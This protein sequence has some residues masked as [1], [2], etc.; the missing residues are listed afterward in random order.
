VTSITRAFADSEGQP[1]IY[2]SAADYMTMRLA[3][4]ILARPFANYAKSGLVSISW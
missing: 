4:N 2:E 3:V 1:N